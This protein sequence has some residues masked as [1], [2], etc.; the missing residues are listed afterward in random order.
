M[1]WS[2]RQLRG[3]LGQFL[4]P[5]VEEDAV[6]VGSNILSRETV[7]TSVVPFPNPPRSMA[8]YSKEWLTIGQAS[9]LAGLPVQEIIN[10]CNSKKLRH[11]RTN[12]FEVVAVSREDV[13]KI[14]EARTVVGPAEF[15][16]VD[17]TPTP[18]S[19]QPTVLGQKVIAGNPWS[20]RGHG[21]TGSTET[22]EDTPPQPSPF[23]VRRK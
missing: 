9:S 22:I 21:Q 18:R 2:W 17:E 16:P 15:T 8:D 20:I 6:I 10:L 23:S 5:R 11:K 14:R 12:S 19:H 13:E 7:R 3:M 1:A 4:G